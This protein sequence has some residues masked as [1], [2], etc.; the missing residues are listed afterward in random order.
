MTWME[1]LFT[2]PVAISTRWPSQP[3]PQKKSSVVK[4]ATVASLSTLA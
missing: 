2:V 4:A 1:L 3:V